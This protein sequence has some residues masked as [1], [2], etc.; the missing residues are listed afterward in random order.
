MNPVTRPGPQ[1]TLE[2]LFAAYL[3]STT[4]DAGTAGRGGRK[5]PPRHR[6]D[7][8]QSIDLLRSALNGYGYQ[9]LTARELGRYQRSYNDGDE[10]AL[11]RLFGVKVL[12]AYLDEYFDDFLI[13][14]VLFRVEDLEATIAETGRFIDWLGDGAHVTPSAA[15]RARKRVEQAADE[16]PAA[17]RLSHALYLEAKRMPVLPGALRDAETVEDFLVVRR[18]SPGKIWFWDLTGALEVPLEVSALTRPGWSINLVMARVN[19]SWHILESRQRL[20]AGHR[21]AAARDSPTG[22]RD[23]DRT[24]ALTGRYPGL[25]DWNH[26]PRSPARCLRVARWRGGRARARLQVVST[27]GLPIRRH[28]RATHRPARDLEAKSLRAADFDLHVQ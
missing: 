1:P 25:R 3:G 2:D 28:T 21:L 18:V 14:K 22:G 12:L 23:A 20:P 11:C 8:E 26:R 9:Y 24:I 17:E 15:A 27:N 7:A 6:P 16:I 10:G 4:A 19:G 13:R 5:R